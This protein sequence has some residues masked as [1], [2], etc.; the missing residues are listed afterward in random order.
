MKMKKNALYILFLL[1]LTAFACTREQEIQPSPAVMAETPAGEAA[2]TP[3]VAIVELDE[4]LTALIEDALAAGSLETKSG[5]LDGVLADLGVSSLE[6][7]FP[8]AGEWE[9]RHR[10]AGLHRFYAV[11]FSTETPVTKAVG[12]LSAVPGVLKVSPSRKIR[13]RA[14]FN[15]RYLNRQWHLVNTKTP[16]ADIHVQEVWEQYT[17]GDPSVIVA[18]M[19]EA[20]DYQHED[21]AGNIWTDGK[22]HYGYNAILDDYSLNPVGRNGV[23]HGT[24]VAGII[25]AVNNNGLGVCGIAGGDAGAGLPGVQVMPIALLAV[26]DQEVNAYNNDVDD[27]ITSRAF[28]WSCDHGALIS[29]NS[30]GLWA[31]GILDGVED[32]KVSREELNYFKSL[33]I[34]DFPSVKAGVDYFIQYAGCDLDGNQRPDAPM[35]GGLVLFAAGNEGDLGNDYDPYCVYEPIISVGAFDADG[36]ASFFSQFGDWVDIAAPGGG[37][38]GIWSTLPNGYAYLGYGGADWVGT[39]MACPHASG[40]AALIISYFGGPGFTAQRCKE[41]LFGGLSETVGGAKPV[42]RRLN[43]LASFEYGINGGFGPEPPHENQPP[44]ISL[45]KTMVSVRAHQEVELR[46]FI[47]DPD[48]DPLTVECQPGSTALHFDPEQGTVRIT[49]NQASPGGYQAVFTVTDP[50]GLSASAT[51]QYALYPNHAP[52]LVRPLED[53]VIYNLDTP[54]RFSVD[55]IFTDEDGET[56]VV[57]AESSRPALLEAHIFEGVLNLT[58]YGYG[59]AEVTLTA[60]DALGTSATQTLH[61]AV[62][63]PGKTLEVYPTATTDYAYVWVETQGTVP[64]T[65]EVYSATGSRVLRQSAQGSVH[66]PIQLDVTGLAPGNYTVAATYAGATR[67]ARLIKY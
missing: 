55:G 48:G 4:A 41:I 23:G 20:I 58:A 61:V 15:D 60:T 24:H 37:H 17:T 43:A 28:A 22:G 16:A 33:T 3:G 38:S 62:K 12:D 18:V 47:S 54:A 19:D 36:S 49:G 35:K 40:V 8:D 57:R 29:Q 31:D 6:R 25:A 9:P 67:K 56:P 34:D 59:L 63:D 11:R 21:L 42:G 39:S 5:A 66:Q 44:Q 32:G 64:V 2:C 52:Q 46:V 53:Q 1:M 10:K 27:L 30:W 14:G 7:V 51:L 13:L 65:I 45:E 26:T 50:E